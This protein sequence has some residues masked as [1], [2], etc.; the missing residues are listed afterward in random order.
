MKDT[1]KAQKG[2]TVSIVKDEETGK[3]YAIV[4]DGA[5]CVYTAE[6]RS[7]A[8][9]IDEVEHGGNESAKLFEKFTT[10]K[11]DRY[12]AWSDVEAGEDYLTYVAARGVRK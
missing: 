9:Y 11:G 1:I 6:M 5:K 4:I 12:V 3:H 10:V 8:D 7:M 2:F